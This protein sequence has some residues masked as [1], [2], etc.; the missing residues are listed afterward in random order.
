MADRRRQQN[1]TALVHYLTDSVWRGLQTAG[2]EKATMMLMQHCWNLG[3]RCPSESTFSVMHNLVRLCAENSRQ[4]TSF[5]IYQS[6][7][8]FK[9]TWRTYKLAHRGEDHTYGDY[10]EV[11][12]QHSA[13]L[14]AEYHLSAFAVEGLAPAR[15]S[16]C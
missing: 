9:K 11:L 4:Q 14:P 6:L 1:Y 5:E 16:T 2:R 12:P 7:N 3:L 13:E 10:L 15:F 8:Q